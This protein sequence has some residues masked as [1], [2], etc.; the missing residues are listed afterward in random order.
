MRVPLSAPATYRPGM[1]M[2]A[3]SMACRRSLVRMPPMVTQALG[4]YCMA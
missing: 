2:P 1:A 4:S 3:S